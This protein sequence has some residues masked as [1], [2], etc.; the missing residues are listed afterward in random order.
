MVEPLRNVFNN[1][2]RQ[3]MSGTDNGNGENWAKNYMA[4]I[5]MP[6]KKVLEI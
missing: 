5:A 1:W 6:T 2:K 4:K 3:E